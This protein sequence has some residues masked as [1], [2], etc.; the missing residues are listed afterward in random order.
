M[1]HG[2]QS[3]ESGAG[4]AVGVERR[5]AERFP[6]DLEPICHEQGSGRGEWVA[7]GVHNISATGIGLVVPHQLR[8]GTVLVIRL[9]SSTRAVSRPLV[10][11]VMHAT[12]QGNGSWLTGAVFVRRLSPQGLRELLS[13]GATA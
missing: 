12:A 6:C 2:E 13:E 10:V 3:G 4:Q 7:L 5:V 9:T 1:S 11:R 8:P